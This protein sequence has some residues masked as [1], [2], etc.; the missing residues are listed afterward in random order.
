[1]TVGELIEKLQKLDQELIIGVFGYEIERI[2]ENE[3]VNGDRFYS[4]G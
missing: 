1:M 4:I 3:D 2:S